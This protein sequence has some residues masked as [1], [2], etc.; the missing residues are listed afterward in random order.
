[1]NQ[2]SVNGKVISHQDIVN[3]MLPE[4]LFIDISH[5]YFLGDAA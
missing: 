4:S 1:M 5:L 3:N 2:T